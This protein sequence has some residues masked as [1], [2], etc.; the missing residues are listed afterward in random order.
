VTIVDIDDSNRE[1]AL[2]ADLCEPA[3]LGEPRFDCIILTQTLQFL[4]DPAVGLENC[5][6]ALR[7][8][9]TLLVTVPTVSR[10][11]PDAEGRDYWRFT[12]AGLARFL[13]M[14]LT[15]S[16]CQP[17]IA[18]TGAGNVTT[19]SA[20]L[21]GLAAEELRDEDL[22]NHDPAFAIVACARVSKPA[23]DC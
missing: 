20:F 19:A 13:E 16:T 23:T 22:T 3:S 8:G 18:V 11:D 5:W 1:V 17:E 21:Y 4:L 12:P 6:T 14:T 9:G 10:E 15:T 7:P 2:I